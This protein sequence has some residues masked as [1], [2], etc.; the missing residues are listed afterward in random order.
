MGSN[1]EQPITPESAREHTLTPHQVAEIFHVDV[2]TVA[3][4]ANTGALT[5][6][7]T[8][9][10]HRRYREDDVTALLNQSTDH[11]ESKGGDPGHSR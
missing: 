10:G 5:C 9:G 11:W 4:W 8:P 6:I 1:D 2:K 7:R 3:R